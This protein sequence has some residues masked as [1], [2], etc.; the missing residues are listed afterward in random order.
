MN[1]NNHNVLMSLFTCSQYNRK[2]Y[3]A[4]LLK[5]L[6]ILASLVRSD[7]FRLFLIKADS[8][9]KASRRNN[10]EPEVDN[11]D[12]NDVFIPIKNE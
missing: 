8:F 11:T 3:R 10:I 9:A 12:V 5:L 2:H 1:E 4:L 6:V 7:P